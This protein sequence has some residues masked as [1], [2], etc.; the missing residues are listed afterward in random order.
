MTGGDELPTS[1]LTG[2]DEAAYFCGHCMISFYR[3]KRGLLR[4][5]R[6]CPNCGETLEPFFDDY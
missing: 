1:G 2:P 4:R 5:K 6:P 3:K